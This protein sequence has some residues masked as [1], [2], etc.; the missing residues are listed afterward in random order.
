[1]TINLDKKIPR[2]YERERKYQDLEVLSVW[3]P[4][5]QLMAPILGFEL[6]MS[7]V[8]PVLGSTRRMNMVEDIDAC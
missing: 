5:F 4:M 3:L 2:I 6:L 8:I 1:M 7:L